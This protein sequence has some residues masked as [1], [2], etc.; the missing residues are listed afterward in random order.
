MNRESKSGEKREF[1]R[2]ETRLRAR[3]S[4]LGGEEL[5]HADVIDVSLGGL[6]LNGECTAGEGTDVVVKI[7]LGEEPVEYLI[8]ALGKIVR[9][10]ERGVAVELVELESPDSLEHLKNLVLY[11]STVPQTI[12]EEFRQHSGISRKTKPL[13]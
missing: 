4:L 6:M 8:E 5:L 11:N 10:D 1:S 13:S 2:V 3:L 12:E 7:M 9:L